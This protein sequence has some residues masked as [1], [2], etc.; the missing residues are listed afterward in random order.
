MG[1]AIN[2]G[3]DIP[4]QCMVILDLKNL[5]FQRAVSTLPVLSSECTM[6]TVLKGLDIM[7]WAVR[8]VIPRYPGM[9]A[10]GGTGAVSDKGCPDWATVFML[11]YSWAHSGM[12]N[13]VK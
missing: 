12:W 13:V 6:L 7:T 5:T 4:L 2:P 10:G 9:L 8:E 3:Q 11:N 1:K